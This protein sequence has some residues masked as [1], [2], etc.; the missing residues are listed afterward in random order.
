MYDYNL[1]S[2][3]LSKKDCKESNRE[4][5]IL[6]CE[7]TL[8]KE[9]LG[10]IGD[11][12]GAPLVY[13]STK[14]VTGL[15]TSALA[16]Q[17]AKTGSRAALGVITGGVLTVDAFLDGGIIANGAWEI[18]EGYKKAVDKMCKCC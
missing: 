1:V 18:H 5:A 4:E 10:Y 12:I 9:M 15:I 2:V 6:R 11:W 14:A 13:D 3:M 7:L 17:A 8:R 16:K